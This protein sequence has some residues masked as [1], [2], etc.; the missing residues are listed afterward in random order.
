MIFRQIYFYVFF[1]IFFLL[2]HRL[3]ACHTPLPSVRMEEHGMPA[4]ANSVMFDYMKIMLGQMSPS[5]A[6]PSIVSHCVSNLILFL[7]RFGFPQQIHHI[8]HMCVCA[9]R[10]CIVYVR[11]LARESSQASLF[12]CRELQALSSVCRHAFRQPWQ[13]YSIRIFV[14]ISFFRF[15]FG[16]GHFW[17]CVWCVR[18]AVSVCVFY[19]RIQLN[20]K[21]EKTAKYPM[22]RSVL[23][24]ENSFWTKKK[25]KRKWNSCRRR[26][27]P[28]CDPCIHVEYMR[29]V[30]IWYPIAR[31]FRVRE[32]PRTQWNRECWLH[33]KGIY[34]KSFARWGSVAL[35]SYMR[36]RQ[37]STHTHTDSD[38]QKTT[39]AAT[40]TRT[41]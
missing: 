29:S 37:K 15:S 20:E 33:L 10:V 8:L 14:Y 18:C 31:M 27:F 32:M 24:T 23:N 39:E 40:R 38:K 36:L 4:D 1:L 6:V 30:A 22:A 41:S 21:E 3:L 26:I 19:T 2:F 17:K 35:S 34:L 12:G 9:M 28:Q 13:L 11:N 5:H 25:R 7:V 16:S